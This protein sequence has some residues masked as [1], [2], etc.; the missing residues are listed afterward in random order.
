[1]ASFKNFM[2]LF[3]RRQDAS[4]IYDADLLDDIG[5]KV[6][7]KRMAMDK[8]INFIARS[9]STTEFQFMNGVQKLDTPWSYKLN[10]KPN[11]DLSAA[12]FWQ[13]V[14]YKLLSD[15]EVLVIK[16]DTDDLLVADDF[17]RNE[18]ANYSDTFSGV[19]VKQYTFQRTFS[20]DE[21]WY[22]KYNSK[23]LERYVGGLWNDYGTL[24]GRLIE[25]NL[26]NNQIRATVKANVTNG[27]QEQ[28]SA[29]L[30]K[31][32]DKIFQS[33]KKNSV[34]IVPVTKEFDYNEVS[35]GVGDK[36][37]DVNQ[38]SGLLDSFTDDVANILGVP[39]ALIHGQMAEVDQ[40]NKAY[41]K[42]CIQPLLKKIRDELN[43]KLFTESEFRSGKHVETIGID[44]PDLFEMAEAIDKTISSSAF[45]PNEIRRKLGYDP[46]EGGDTFVMTKNYDTTKGSDNNDTTD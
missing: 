28:R 35:G 30:Q 12:N 27:T 14:I 36:N 11:T 10:V 7:A 8:V 2:E 22:M 1:M 15:N 34:A 13:E 40:N 25:I 44:T 9:I 19:T 21:V 4:Y 46:R 39:P 24:F 17:V 38:V 16:N 43:A 3:T 33:F 29:S 41:I 45:S 26:R 37:Q 42:F 5:N 6:Y 18:Y 32:I 20:M 23:E 31:Y